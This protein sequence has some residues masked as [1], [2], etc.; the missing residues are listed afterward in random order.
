MAKHYKFGMSVDDVQPKPEH[1]DFDVYSKS[2]SSDTERPN[3]YGKAW[4]DD[5]KNMSKVEM[6]AARITSIPSPYARMHVTD[7]AFRELNSGSS[8]MT[9]SEMMG[10]VIS[11]DYLHAM[12]HCLDMFELFYYFDDLDLKEKGIRIEK[13]DLV[14]PRDPATRDFFRK[15][16]QTKSYLE[17]LQLF[18]NQYL[19][20][21]DRNRPG[22]YKFHFD[23]L[24]VFL[25]VVS[26]TVIGATSPFTGFFAKSTCNVVTEDPAHEARLTIRKGDYVH[27]L[28]TDNPNDWITLRN[29]PDDFKK[30]LYLLLHKNTENLGVV[31]ANLFKTVEMSIGKDM[32][33]KYNSLTFSQEYPEFNFGDENLPK[34]LSGK[35]AY[36]RVSDMDRSMLKYLLYLYL[37]NPINFDIPKDAYDKPIDQREFPDGSGHSVPWICVNDLLSDALFVLPYDVNQRYVAVPYYDKE[38]KKTYRRCLL[39]IKQRVLEYFPDQSLSDIAKN[40]DIVKYKDHFVVNYKVKMEKK[41]RA[42]NPVYINLRREYKTGN[43]EYPSGI[44]IGPKMMDN[45]AF[46]I[47]PFVRSESY[48]NIYKVL[49]YNKFNLSISAKQPEFHLDFYYFSVNASKN[50]KRPLKFKPDSIK[51]NFTGT[52]NPTYPDQTLNSI[53]YSIQ[54]N[55]EANRT[56]CVE[57]AELC[58]DIKDELGNVLTE[59]TSLIVPLLEDRETKDTLSTYISIDLGTSNTY[60]AY[61]REGE[62]APR[63]INTI[64]VDKRHH[65]YSELQFM[66]EAA[67]KDDFSDVLDQYGHDLYLR[68]SEEPQRGDNESAEEYAARLKKLWTACMPTQFCEFIP[69]HIVPR[70]EVQRNEFTGNAMYRKGAG[71]SFPIPTVINCL[72]LNDSPNRIEEESNVDNVLR[73]NQ[74]LTH[75]SIPFA[76]YEIGKRPNNMDTIAEGDF[77]WFMDNYVPISKHQLNLTMFVSE[78][79]FIVRS[80]MLSEGFALDRCRVYWTYPLSFDKTLEDYTSEIWR[81]AYMK[82]FTNGDIT[83]EELSEKVKSTNESLSPFYYCVKSSDVADFIILMDIGGGSTDIVGYDNNEVQFITSFEFA[84]NALYLNSKRN[85]PYRSD[86]KNIFTYYLDKDGNCK[87][88][89]NSQ[90]K[91]YFGDATRVITG[92]FNASN[93]LAAL[94]N[95]G[96]QMHEKDFKLLFQYPEILFMLKFYAASIVYH[97]AQLCHWYSKNRFEELHK[98]GDTTKKDV[99]PLPNFIWLS[100]NG[101]KLLNLL[102]TEERDR[103]FEQIFMKVYGRVSLDEGELKIKAPANPKVATARGALNAPDNVFNNRPSKSVIML[104]D[105]DTVHKCGRNSRNMEVPRDRDRAKMLKSVRSNVEKFIDIFYEYLGTEY[106]RFSKKSVLLQLDAVEK[107][108]DAFRIGE[109]VTDS[110]FFLYIARIMEKISQRLV[111]DLE[112]KNA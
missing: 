110:F 111:D 102:G 79:L 54:E 49:F 59:G 89:K 16:P 62:A 46:G 26:N 15:N 109:K 98:E 76:Y 93:G 96:F 36:L 12:S 23:A 64:H 33:E 95:Y 18:R 72:R 19:K 67:T 30:F 44:L 66:N 41:D 70:P 84:G 90:K 91:S 6:S 8:T 78:L 10:K 103:L 24:Y 108:E 14:D 69:A 51:E 48:T 57:F 5:P 13:I 35:D 37:D 4:F 99:L 9:E 11:K 43:Y 105:E 75:S 63:E 47:Y 29:R 2:T 28:L 40:L 100:G 88:M 104:G 74:P 3:P 65:Q 1:P 97:T 80:N 55:N 60:V 22:N 85:H 68:P 45:F 27:N 53:Y 106:P 86:E 87:E 56:K 38:T 82:Y 25:D 58:M 94:M 77:K 81:K 21:L 39:P 92:A 101:S 34:I 112:D 50:E 42:G 83:D 31:F 107:Q 32:L 61:K 20:A 17:T 7:L 71:F 52:F 73:D